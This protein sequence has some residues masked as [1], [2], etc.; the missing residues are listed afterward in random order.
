M[1]ENGVGKVIF[2]EPNEFLAAR[3]HAQALDCADKADKS[4]GNYLRRDSFYRDAAALEELAFATYPPERVEARC[5]SAFYAVSFH[6]NSGYPEDVIRSGA[7]FLRNLPQPALE[8][9]GRRI[10]VMLDE[11][12]LRVNSPLYINSQP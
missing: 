6:Y 12:K 2:G 4:R 9:V 5:A 1:K 8:I 3:L 7:H 11:A 10:Q